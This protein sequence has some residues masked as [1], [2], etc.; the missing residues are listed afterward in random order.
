MLQ[1]MLEVKFNEVKS[2]FNVVNSRFDINDHK[3]DVQNAKLNE[4]SSN[5][6][7]QKLKCESNFNELNKRFDINDVKFD[8]LKGEVKQ[9]KEQNAK[10]DENSINVKFYELNKLLCKR[11][12]ERIN[13]I[14]NDTKRQTDEL[15]HNGDIITNNNKVIVDKVNSEVNKN[16]NNNVIDKVNGGV[17]ISDNYNNDMMNN[18]GDII[19]KVVLGS[20]ILNND[21]VDE[22]LME[23]EISDEIVVDEIERECDERLGWQRAYFPYCLSGVKTPQVV[24][25]DRDS[26]RGYVGDEVSPSGPLIFCGKPGKARM[27]YSNFVVPFAWSEVVQGGC[28]RC[29][30]ERYFE[31]EKEVEMFKLKRG[32]GELVEMLN[33]KRINK[34][35]D[36][37][38]DAVS[39]VI[40]DDY[41]E[42]LPMY[43]S[44]IHI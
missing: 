3:F 33:S 12:D 16:E 19:K 25:E 32:Y 22:V 39:V 11:I 36:L 20:K 35:K 1:A 15:K 34:I 37:P 40:D 2:D 28:D 7:E 27:C 31:R 23:V 21:T 43:L 30:D 38:C 6:N 14:H 17:I 9:H 13:E 44:L 4:L 41:I 26:S 10:F 42:Y 8:E 5:V 29:Y 24:Y 18:N